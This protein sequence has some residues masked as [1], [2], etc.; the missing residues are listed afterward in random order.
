MEETTGL[1]EAYT[2][3]ISIGAKLRWFNS[4]RNTLQFAFWYTSIE[5][6]VYEMWLGSR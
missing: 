6:L 4:A 1:K 2:Y 3:A 5:A